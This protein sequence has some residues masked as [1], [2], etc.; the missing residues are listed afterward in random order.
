MS[1]KP[2]MTDKAG[3]A[4]GYMAVCLPLLALLVVGASLIVFESDYLFKVQEL[5]LFLYT[6]LFF[7]QQMVVSGVM[8]TWLGTYFTQYFYYPAL[9]VTLLCLWLALLMWLFKRTFRIAD[10]YAA[11]LLVPLALVLITDVDL[12]Y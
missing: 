12:G 8:L 11:L 9:G 4:L 6:P 10:R 5:N 1:R 3:K 2:D 7:K